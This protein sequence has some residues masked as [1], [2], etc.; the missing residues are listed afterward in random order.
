[1]S[2]VVEVKY[3]DGD[4]DILNLQTL[5]FEA[6]V[7]ADARKKVTRLCWMLQDHYSKDVVEKVLRQCEGGESESESEAKEDNDAMTEKVEQAEPA[8]EAQQQATSSKRQRRNVDRF[9][10]QVQGQSDKESRK[11]SKRKKA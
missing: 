1:M 10:P 7:C 5:E 3:E 11:R 9:N 8:Q 6:R 2:C 4:S